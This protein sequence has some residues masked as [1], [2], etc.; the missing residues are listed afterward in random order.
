MELLRIFKIRSSQFAECILKTS[1]FIFDQ[2]I[3]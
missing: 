1:K 2:L 3:V